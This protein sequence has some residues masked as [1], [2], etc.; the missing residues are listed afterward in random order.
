MGMRVCDAAANV[1]RL[2]D[3][4]A[5]MWGD[6][7]LLHA[8][9]ELAEISTRARSWQTE[10]AVLDALAKTPGELVPRYTTAVRGR[11]VRIFYLPECVPAE[12][13]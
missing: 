7:G 11:R 10:H 13:G 8:I 3:N 4:P 5:V 2:T 1:L 12:R 6:S 9:A